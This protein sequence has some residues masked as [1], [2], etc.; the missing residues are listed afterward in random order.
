MAKVQRSNIIEAENVI[1]VAMCHQHGVEVSQPTTQGLL[2]KISRSVNDYG[3]AGV[4]DQNR[5][6]QTLVARVG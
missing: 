5:N 4:F 1:S 6:P 3:L 2:A